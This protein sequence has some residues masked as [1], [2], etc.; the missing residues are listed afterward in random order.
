MSSYYFTNSDEGPPANQPTVTSDNST[1]CDNGWV[2]EHR[3]S[4]MQPMYKFRAT[5]KG[6]GLNDWWDNGGNQ[7]AFGRGNM[8][9]IAINKDSYTMQQT[10]QTGLPPGEYQDIFSGNQVT[11]S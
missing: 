1:S 3:W 6:T 8:G 2:C 4:A 10:L 9:F 5:V 7:I 11:V